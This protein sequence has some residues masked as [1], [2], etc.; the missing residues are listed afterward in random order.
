LQD[1]SVWSEEKSFFS[2]C[3][4]GST[5]FESSWLKTFALHK[6]E[7]FDIVLRNWVENPR[8]KRKNPKNLYFH[9]LKS[10]QVGGFIREYKNIKLLIMLTWN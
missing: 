7:A 6:L 4:T 2:P 5:N 3:K 8:E 1:Y 9:S 10:H